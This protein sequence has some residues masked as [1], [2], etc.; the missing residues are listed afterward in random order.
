MNRK[1]PIINFSLFEFT[2]R[3]CMGG[4]ISLKGVFLIPLYY[5]QIIPTL[6][7]A[8]LQFLIF[9]R[10]IRKTNISIDPVFI[11]GHYRSGT[12][13]L[14]KLMVSDK[15]FGFL[16]Y[17]DAL[18]PNT[19]LLLGNKMQ[20]VFQGLI[21]MFKIKNPFFH[22]SILQLSEPDEEEDYLMN[23][24]SAYSAYWGIIF[25][26]RWREW[27]NG[28]VQMSD[29]K[30]L[31]GWKKEYQRTLQYVTFR[32]NG[33]QL[34]LKSPPNTERIRVL[35]EM[36]PKAKFIFLARNPFFL[37]YSILNMWKRAI[38][39]YYS[40][41]KISEAELEELV[42]GHFE[43]LMEQYEKDKHLIPN[44]NIVEISYEELKADSVATI[45]KIYSEIH[46]PD[47][48]ITA[49][50]LAVQLEKEKDYQNFY[51]QCNAETFNRIYERWGKYIQRW[52]YKVPDIVSGAVL[53]NISK[54]GLP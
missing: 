52:N 49:N 15:R 50:D 43:Y 22:N 24:V 20:S 29:Q 17:Y 32:N 18:F 26:A 30:Y 16:N 54:S 45:Q 27:L 46:L 12:T 41:Q 36:F 39:K 35:L 13:L 51:H 48:E 42:F 34:V 47:F 19:N 5:L 2:R 1:F 33:K 40:V 21:H 23:K 10:R 8:F 28:S 3:A 44:G 4:R 31:C 14:Q 9:G 38:L 7:L 11:L 6:P 25:P 53:N 37:Y